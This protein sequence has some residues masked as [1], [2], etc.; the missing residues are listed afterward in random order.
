MFQSL[1]GMSI[2]QSDNSSEGTIVSVEFQ[3]FH[4]K[5]FYSFKISLITNKLISTRI[6]LYIL[7]LL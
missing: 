3:N 2:R 7:D 4:A 6:G 1:L 5:T